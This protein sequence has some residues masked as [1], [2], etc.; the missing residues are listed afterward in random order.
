MS[1]KDFIALAETISRIENADERKR[2]AR[3]IGDVCAEHNRLFDWNR[4]S[5]ACGVEG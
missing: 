3:A 1:K 4:W 5:R 2:V